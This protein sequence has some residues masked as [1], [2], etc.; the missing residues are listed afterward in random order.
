MTHHRTHQSNGRLADV[1]I[2]LI[3]IL[4]ANRSMVLE[5]CFVQ[6]IANGR[7][8]VHAFVKGIGM[9]QLLCLHVVLIKDEAYKD[10]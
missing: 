7:V 9:V 1:V 2:K 4:D 8:A 10:K 6:E 3:C 5:E